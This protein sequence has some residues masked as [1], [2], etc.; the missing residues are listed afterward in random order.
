MKKIL[1]FLL[2]ITLSLTLLLALPVRAEEELSQDKYDF[3]LKLNGKLFRFLET[4]DHFLEV[5][6]LD[7]PDSFWQGWKEPYDIATPIYC[8]TEEID[9]ESEPKVVIGFLNGNQ[10]GEM[11][12]FELSGGITQDSNLDEVV[13]VY[14]MP[15]REYFYTDGNIGLDY[16]LPNSRYRLIF[17]PEGLLESLQIY[18]QYEYQNPENADEIRVQQFKAGTG[19]SDGKRLALSEDLFD[20]TFYM[21]YAYY[22]LPVQ[23]TELAKDG[24]LLVQKEQDTI[25]A[26]ESGGYSILEKNNQF[27]LSE[28]LNPSEKELPAE[29]AD[30]MTIDVRSL[31]NHPDR[32][33]TRVH[34]ELPR[35]I[36]LGE[37][38]RDEV[39]KAY[40]GDYKM[41]EQEVHVR[42]GYTRLEL[43]HPERE[44]EGY[45]FTFY[46]DILVEVR[47]N[48]KRAPETYQAEL[49]EAPEYFVKAL[50]NLE[51]GHESAY[52]LRRP[53]EW[54]IEAN[55][56]PPEYPVNRMDKTLFEAPQLQ[57]LIVEVREKYPKK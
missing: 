30:L 1:S 10:G 38:T 47:I 43:R 41:E 8:L 4:S 40:G 7:K 46:R 32:G 54:E 18:H 11:M 44:D 31:E 26:G 49:E 39:E 6:G 55:A 42:E 25:P 14:G 20:Y 52:V 19:K 17:D 53:E 45:D 57:D 36:I 33:P 12:P 35:G 27:L 13:Q 34:L 37:S 24:W 16:G 3:E 2:L 50:E 23:P 15:S 22:Q 56:K 5:T 51:E 28:L 29:E 48:A 9:P 21:D